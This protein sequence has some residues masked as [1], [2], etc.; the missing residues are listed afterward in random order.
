ME[1]NMFLI[2]GWRNIKK[3]VYEKI[4]LKEKEKEELEK[5]K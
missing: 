4:C 3:K 1:E 2:K 5:M